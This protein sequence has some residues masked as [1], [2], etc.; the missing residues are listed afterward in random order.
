MSYSILENPVAFLGLGSEP[1][2]CPKHVIWADS[3]SGTVYNQNA[4]LGSEE[5]YLDNLQGM[6]SMAEGRGTEF[7]GIPLRDSEC[8]INLVIA[9]AIHFDGTTLALSQS[10][11]LFWW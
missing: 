3:L 4:L 2:Q 11:Y 9:K 5:L 7:S 6:E 10:K 1:F 8:E